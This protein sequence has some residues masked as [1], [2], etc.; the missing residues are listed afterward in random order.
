MKLRN[1][2]IKKLLSVAL[3]AALIGIPIGQTANAMEIS[4]DIP[5]YIENNPTTIEDL[6]INDSQLPK[7]GTVTYI[8][9]NKLIKNL[10]EN[11]IDTTL[12][13]NELYYRKAGTNKIV[14]TKTGFDLY[15]SKGVVLT[16]AGA[17]TGVAGLLAG[18]IP[19]IGQ[20]LAAAIVGAITM[21]LG[22]N[23]TSGKIFKFKKMRYNKGGAYV[24]KYYLQ[25]V[26]NQ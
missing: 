15:L 22:S 3:L 20:Y 4:N 9:I 17:G 18:A 7:P 6:E 19:G 1:P 2:K 8:D 11:G 23:I 16:L 21:H 25:S 26:R 14:W 24:T 12:I 10:K 13:E 5:S